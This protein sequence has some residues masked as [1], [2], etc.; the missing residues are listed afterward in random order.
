VVDYPHSTR[1]KKFFLVLMVGPSMVSM[2]QVRGL[3]CCSCSG[4]GRFNLW[5]VRPDS[6]SGLLQQVRACTHLTRGTQRGQ[7]AAGGA[8]MLTCC[9]ML[10]CAMP[11]C[12]VLCC[13]CRPRALRQVHMS[14]C[15]TMTWRT[16][17]WERREWRR[18]SE[19]NAAKVRLQGRHQQGNGTGQL[20][21]GQAPTMLSHPWVLGGR[22]LVPEYLG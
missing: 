3:D 13:S 1:A 20:H 4:P 5:Y 15:R 21:C 7:H 11:W 18:G 14:P 2:P 8:D 17:K 6:T 9:L 22:Q 19:E 16:Q 10:C 12:A